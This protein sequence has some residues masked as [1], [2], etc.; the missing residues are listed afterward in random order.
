MNGNGIMQEIRTLLSSGKPSGEVIALGYKPGT[1]YKV[2]R[3]MRG[4]APGPGCNR[5]QATAPSP[6]TPDAVTQADLDRWPTVDDLFEEDEPLALYHLLD[7]D[8]PR[9][10]ERVE[11]LHSELGQARARIKVLE[12]EAG[13][14]QALKERVRALESSTAELKRDIL[15]LG[16]LIKAALEQPQTLFGEMAQELEVQ[17]LLD[18]ILSQGQS[19]H[20][21]LCSPSATTWPTLDSRGRLLVPPSMACRG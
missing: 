9:L 7:H 4:K 14:A 1:V 2:H 5:A 21:S 11:S 3:Q 16:Q 17:G 15:T 10:S 12:V 18:Q 8:F 19:K 13:Q 20:R 6:L